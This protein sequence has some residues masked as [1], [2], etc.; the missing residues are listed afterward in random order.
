[1]TKYVLNSGGLR[2]NLPRAREFFA[3]VVKG[4]GNSPKVLICYFAQ[5]REM[6]EEKFEEL[7]K[8]DLYPDGVQPEY[9][10]AL[11]DIFEQQIKDTDVLYIYGGDDHLIQYWL[12]KYSL[13]QVWEGKV[14]ATNSASTN[15]LSTSFW[16]CDW[17]KIMNG[18]ALLPIKTLPHYLSDFGNDDPRGPVDWVSAL[19]ELEQYGD[20]HLPVYALKE[21]EFVTFE[22]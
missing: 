14:V 20:T 19:N 4:L 2:N 18:L 10:L 13:P 11:P 1:M 12:S 17:R 15:M 5:P 6:W 7:K 22:V 8:S 21:G 16:T 9:K 3:E